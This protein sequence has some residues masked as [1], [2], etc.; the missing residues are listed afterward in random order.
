MPRVL[1]QRSAAPTGG[2]LLCVCYCEI[3]I[4]RRKRKLLW[5]AAVLFQV[6]WDRGRWTKKKRSGTSQK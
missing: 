1:P 6:G 5:A 4:R 3:I 2:L